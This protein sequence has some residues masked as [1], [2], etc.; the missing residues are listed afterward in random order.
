M[1]QIASFTV[2]AALLL[3]GG[4]NWLGIRGNGHVVTD[5]RAIP[6]FTEFSASGGMKVEW[7]SGP[8][9]LAI[10]TDENLLQYIQSSVSGSKLRLRTHDHI[11]PTHHIRVTI[12]SPKLNGAELSGAV[13]LVAHNLSG[14]KFY[15]RGTGASDI[16]VD[17]S[18]DELLADITGA[19]DLRAKSLLVKTAEISVTGA[20]DAVVNVSDA[21]R[22]SITGAGDVVYYGN[23]KT[24]EKH[25]VGAGSVTRKQ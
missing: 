7:R 4:C 2:A 23:P 12:T 5:Q 21:L 20:G 25:V 16:T 17:G 8:P 19:G 11:R 24:L 15:V 22:V 13:D 9:S 14:S 1:K 10:T 3:L 18:V 6:D